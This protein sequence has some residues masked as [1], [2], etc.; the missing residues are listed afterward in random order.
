[1]LDC[2]RQ[3]TP[4]PAELQLRRAVDG[5]RTTIVCLRREIENKQGAVGRL[6]TLLRERLTRIDELNA[7]LEQAREQNR[8][9]EAEAEH[10]AAVI[11]ASPDNASILATH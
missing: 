9:L 5:L 4:T 2:M 7:K 6:E 3:P 1:M 10:L 8:R 11:A